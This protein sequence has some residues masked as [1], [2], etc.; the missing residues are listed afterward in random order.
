MKARAE[1]IAGAWW[2]GGRIT[3]LH[4]P[5]EL[6]RA[7]YSQPERASFSTPPCDL[8][9]TGEGDF[10]PIASFSFASYSLKSSQLRTFFFFCYI[11]YPLCAHSRGDA[12]WLIRVF[13]IWNEFDAYYV[14][15]YIIREDAQES[16]LLAYIRVFAGALKA[17]TS[18]YD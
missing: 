16:L 18:P 15:S 4:L 8:A 13:L 11:F 1:N 6:A 12:I 3:R 2:T 9:A 14:Y 7:A 5:P 17:G 10:S